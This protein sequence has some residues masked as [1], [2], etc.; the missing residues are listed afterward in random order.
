MTEDSSSSQHCQ[1]VFDKDKSPPQSQKS[2]LKTTSHQQSVIKAR[3]KLW[4]EF[5]FS[6]KSIYKCV[7]DDK[8]Y[9]TV[10]SNMWQQPSY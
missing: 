10:E 5:F 4:R 3:L 9:F 8:S 2:A 6:L 1:K 7:M